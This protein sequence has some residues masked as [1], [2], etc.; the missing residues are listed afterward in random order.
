M[1]TAEKNSHNIGDTV[2]YRKQGIYKISDIKEQKIGTEKKNYYVLS[3]VYDVN[4]TVYVPVDNEALTSKMEH[5]LSKDEIDTIIDK[6]E[7][8]DV[9]WIENT[10]ERALYLDEIV[11]SGDLARILAMLKMF[12]LRRE[13]KDKKPTRTFARD[14]K[15]FAAA[16][17]AVTEAFAYPLGLEKPQVMPYITERVKESID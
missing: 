6:S 5:I 3:S 13:N 2:V 17:K 4:A 14:E 11:K 12:I 10:T 9:E 16:Q 7:K 1:Q 15:A 8:N